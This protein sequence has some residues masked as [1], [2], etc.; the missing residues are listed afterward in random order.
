M[1][2]L[3]NLKL[4]L[5]AVSFYT[6][7]PC[8]QT[9]NYRLL[10]EATIY[11]PLVGWLV[12]AIVAL[13][14][15]MSSFLWSQMTSVIL[16]LMC[17]IFLTGAF[18][19]DGL[20]DVCDGFGGGWGKAAILKIMKDSHIGVYC[21]LGLLLLFILKINLLSEL[22]DGQVPWILIS[23]HSI[24]RLPPLLLMYRYDYVR[25][26]ESKAGNAVHKINSKELSFAIGLALLPLLLL[27]NTCILAIFP[28]VLVNGFLG[29]Y[30]YRHIGGYTGDCLGASQQIAEVVFYLS[31]SALWI[32]I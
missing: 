28:I 32:F 13:C 9:L 4:I 18:H 7:I 20:V 26:L 1:P 5:V 14:F 30:F 22:K 11:L 3:I 29:S 24:S 27:P 23:G 8:R 25:N 31:V 17:G 10:P 16:A 19:E 6:R 12:G 15:Y 2:H 21:V